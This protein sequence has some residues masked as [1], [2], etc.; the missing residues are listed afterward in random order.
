[1]NIE[2]HKKRHIELHNAF[3]ELLADFILHAYGRPSMKIFDLIMWSYKQTQELDHNPEE[4]EQ[5][6]EVSDG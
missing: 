3:D 5:G 6:K 4:N 2:D 1:M